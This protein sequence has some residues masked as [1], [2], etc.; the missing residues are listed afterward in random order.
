MSV[1]GCDVWG[2]SRRS[3]EIVDRHNGTIVVALDSQSGAKFVVT[4]PIDG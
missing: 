4:L 1:V 3:G 2:R